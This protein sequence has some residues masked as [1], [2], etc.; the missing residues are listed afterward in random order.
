MKK[1]LLATAATLAM[2]AT[3][4]NAA[5]FGLATEYAIEA[6]DFTTTFGVGQAFGSIYMSAEAELIDTDFEGV[7]V[8]VTYGL[9]ADVSLYG[10]VE[11]DDGFEYDEAVVGIALNF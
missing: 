9:T 5:D 4:S 6:E 10:V 2:A 8:G 1:I 3:A 11:F 7:D